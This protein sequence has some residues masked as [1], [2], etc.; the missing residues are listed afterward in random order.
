MAI[1]PEFRNQG[2]S[3]ELLEKIQ[4]EL[5]RR[6]FRG[7]ITRT[8]GSNEIHQQ[9]LSKRGWVEIERNF[10]ARSSQEDTVYW[11]ILFN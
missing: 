1:H 6:N 10:K 4:S 3:Q 7:L 2:L 8:W 11:A 5:L 9:I